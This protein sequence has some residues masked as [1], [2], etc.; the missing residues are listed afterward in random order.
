MRDAAKKAFETEGVVLVDCSIDSEELVLPMIP[1][2]GTI[3][4]IIM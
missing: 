1:P 3:N 4:N 2:G